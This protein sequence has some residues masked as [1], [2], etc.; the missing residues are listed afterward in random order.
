MGMRDQDPAYAR[1]GRREHRLHVG[2]DRRTGVDDGDLL[3]DDVSDETEVVA[4]ARE[5]F[6]GLGAE[7]TAVDAEVDKR[8]D[9]WT[10]HRLAVVDR[11]ILRLGT[12]EIIY[13]KDTPPKVALNEYIELAKRYGSEAKTAK[14]VNGVLDRIARHHRPGE[15]TQRIEKPKPLEIPGVDDQA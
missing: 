9:N 8:L 7:R 6:A 11:A 3:T 12:Y 14:L 5:L 4:F 2:I 10:I 1:A 13:N 15:V